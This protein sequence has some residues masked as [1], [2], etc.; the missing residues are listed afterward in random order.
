[1]ASN[2]A[3]GPKFIDKTAQKPRLLEHFCWYRMFLTFEPLRI[4]SLKWYILKLLIWKTIMKSVSGHFLKCSETLQ[5]YEN[6]FLFLL[7]KRFYVLW[8]NVAE[9]KGLK[10]RLICDWMSCQNIYKSTHIFTQ[11]IFEVHEAQATMIFSAFLNLLSSNNLCSFQSYPFDLC[12][13]IRIKEWISQFCYTH[14]SVVIN[15]SLY[16]GSNSRLTLHIVAKSF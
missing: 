3:Q 11:I 15:Q 2:E 8:T 16:V 14:K 1:M 6:L 5:N 7:F 4:R 9:T 10:I 12:K 13:I